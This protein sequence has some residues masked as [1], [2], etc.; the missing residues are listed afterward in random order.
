[1]KN[2]LAGAIAGVLMLV[3]MPLLAASNADSA[4]SGTASLLNKAHQINK[5]K[6]IWPICLKIKL[7]TIRPL[8]H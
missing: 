7:A 1:M 2:I 3:A 8:P 6:W 4:N 5:A